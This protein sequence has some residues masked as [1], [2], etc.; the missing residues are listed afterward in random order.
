MLTAN[1]LVLLFAHHLRTRNDMSYQELRD[2][3]GQLRCLPNPTRHELLVEL[4]SN[5]CAEHTNRNRSLRRAAGV[6]VYHF[7]DFER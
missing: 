5:R 7:A 4:V 2:P 1:S 3:A 6:R